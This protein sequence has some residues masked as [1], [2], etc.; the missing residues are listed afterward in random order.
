MI[1]FPFRLSK[2]S[3]SSSF[4]ESTFL[5]KVFPALGTRVGDAL[6]SL[7]VIRRQI[8]LFSERIRLWRTAGLQREAQYQTGYECLRD[9]GK[10]IQNKTINK[11]PKMSY[12]STGNTP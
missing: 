6:C 4:P 9:P 10:V 5:E 1:S 8:S 2:Q 11:T 3:P 12:F 7:Q